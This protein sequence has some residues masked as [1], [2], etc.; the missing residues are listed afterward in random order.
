[1]SKPK[2]TVEFLLSHGFR[3]V[4][5]WL[6][7]NDRLLAPRALPEQAGVYAF[8]IDEAVQYVGLASRSLRQRLSFYRAPGA[9]QRT[10]I[11]LNSK[12]RQE[13]G[14][15]KAVRVFIAHPEDGTWNGLRLRGAEGLE[16][17]L[18]EDFELPWNMRGAAPTAPIIPQH[19]R[20]EAKTAARVPRGSVTVRIVDYV[21]ANPKSTELQIAQGVFGPTALQPRANPYCRKLV[22]DGRLE[23][24][25]TRPATYIVRE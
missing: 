18:I 16:A 24:L 20:S 22:E 12:I 7:H 19:S 1:M 15:D 5:C 9:S 13:L 4:D 3:E 21:K 6:L 25:P 10:N 11:R 14:D 8:A 17:A 23:R 2:L